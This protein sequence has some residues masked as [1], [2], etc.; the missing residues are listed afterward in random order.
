MGVIYNRWG[1]LI[2]YMK[3]IENYV[4]DSHIE[5]NPTYDKK[6]KEKANEFLSFFMDKNILSCLHFYLDPLDL[7]TEVSLAFQ[8]KY[9]S[10]VGVSRIQELMEEKFDHIREGNG[11]MLNKFLQNA[12]CFTDE[13]SPGYPCTNLH[14]Y[15]NSFKVEYMGEVLHETL[16]QHENQL[17]TVYPRL[18]TYMGTYMTM[19][20]EKFLSYFPTHGDPKK[21]KIKMSIFDPL[22]QRNYPV[23]PQEKATFA[24]DSIEDIAKLFSI[25]PTGLQAEF[26]RIVHEAFST[27]LHCQLRKSEP[28]YYWS[29]LMNKLQMSPKMKY[30]LRSVFTI[31]YSS[32]EAERV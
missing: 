16:Y 9:S 5:K 24:P 31:P 6:S 23:D 17:F 14:A 28:L 21:G 4:F 13:L 25:D 26:V 11:I 32:A 10:L 30:V 29:V 19:I 8:L 27:G 20:K 3:T 22:D 2:G 1:D 18:S 7:F 12:M 15:E